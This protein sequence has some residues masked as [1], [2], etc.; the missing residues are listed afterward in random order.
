[1]NILFQDYEVSKRI[2]RSAYQH[3]EGKKLEYRKLT[4]DFWFIIDGSAFTIKKGFWWDGA[5]IPRIFW[6]AIGDPWEADIAPGALIHDMLYACQYY[7]RWKADLIMFEVNKLNGMNAI[8]NHAVY[9]ALRLGGW[10]AWNDKTD[11]M[12]K[13]ASKHLVI[14]G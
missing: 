3:P 4:Q 1:M 14:N 7:Q 9:R 6:T 11:E 12:I 2:F 8:K 10:K 5:S 13:G